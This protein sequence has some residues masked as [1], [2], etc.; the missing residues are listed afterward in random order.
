MPVSLLYEW[1]AF[2]KMEP[3]GYEMDRARWEMTEYRSFQRVGIL[4]A[5]VLNSLPGKRRRA[6]KVKDFIPES[7]IPELPAPR[8]QQA[9]DPAALYQKL[10]MA[11]G[12]V[13]QRAND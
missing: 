13:K 11:F 5:N 8:M 7:V 3:W 12:L 9:E 2:H 10:K 4:L 1:I 6:Y